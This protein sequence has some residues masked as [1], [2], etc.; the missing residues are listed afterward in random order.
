ML[1]TLLCQ[2]APLA[3]D[4]P[5]AAA[6]ATSQP[7]ATEAALAVLGAGGNAFDAAVAAAAVLGVVEPYASGLGG[8]GLWLLWRASDAHLILVDGR[9]TAPG[10]A[11]R[12][13][14]LDEL[15]EV[16]R[17]K[18]T[19]GPLAAAIPG[20]PA[21]LAH[22]AR[23]YGRVPLTVS[24]GPAIQL[25][26]EGFPVSGDYRRMAELRRAALRRSPAA[27]ATFLERGEVPP[28]GHRIVQPDLARTLARLAAEGPDG[29]YRGPTGQ[30]LVA[31]VRAA[32][33]IWSEADLAGYRVIERRPVIGEYRGWRIASAPPPSS[34]GV[35]LVEALNVLSGYDR[36]ALPR[37]AWVHRVT[38][39]LRRVFRDRAVYLGDPDFVRVPVGL[40]TE[41]AYAAGLRAGISPG[42]ASSSA[43]LPG[44]ADQAPGADHTSHLS[45]LDRDGNRVAATLTVN[46]PFGSGF[47]APGTGV[48]LNNQMDDF[49]A[50]P[51]VP[52]AYGLVGGEANAIA[53]GKRPLSSMS[54]TF[55]D[56]AM[57]A[58]ALGTPGGSRIISVTLLALL[59]LAEGRGPQAWVSLPRFHH[60]YLPDQV[61]FEA[62]ALSTEEVEAL[63][64]MGHVLRPVDQPYGN[65]QAL[66]WDRAAGRVLA[67]SDPRGGGLAVVR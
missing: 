45:V 28:D 58:A 2:R 34:G 38:E 65:M 37:V 64:A 13:M 23:T 3:A 66:F 67:A 35:A 24:L 15:A 59:E 53:P 20:L 48:V 12:D 10:A 55:A 16:D 60:Q 9:E 5:P 56:S 26:R 62:G 57:G 21:S 22:V 27:A 6:V 19:D 39:T 49:S 7:G 44:L 30:M 33:G 43:D 18:A 4:A 61:E 8:G 32:G 40:L 63:E 36:S 25:A 51:G 14:F 41:P 52:N 11:H 29:F 47:V 31:G 1:A 54:P 50:K 46:G 42:R 17:E